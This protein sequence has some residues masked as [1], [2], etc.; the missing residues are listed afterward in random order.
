MWACR[1]HIGHDHDVPVCSWTMA[2]TSRYRGCR[3]HF[4]EPVYTNPLG[5]SA[6]SVHSCSRAADSQWSPCAWGIQVDTCH[7]PNP[8]S[9][10]SCPLVDSCQ[11]LSGC[12][13]P[14]WIIHYRLGSQ[15]HC[16]CQG[17]ARWG[18]FNIL[19]SYRTFLRYR[20]LQKCSHTLQ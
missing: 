6:S 1:H 19:I 11:Y 8:Y 10:P 15:C 14:S 18:L 13:S 12:F 16:Q 9:W 3:H 7:E 4:Q 2:D 5:P 17:M 20:D